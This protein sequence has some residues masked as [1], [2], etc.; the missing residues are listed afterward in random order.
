LISSAGNRLQA[1]KALGITRTTLY[2]KMRSYG[3]EEIPAS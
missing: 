3:L 1:A 2:K